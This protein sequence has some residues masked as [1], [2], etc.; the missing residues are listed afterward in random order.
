MPDQCVLQL[1]STLSQEELVFGF[2]SFSQAY[3]GVKS[4]PLF[5][6]PS[7]HKFMY[8]VSMELRHLLPPS[9]DIEFEWNALHPLI[10]GREDISFALAIVAIIDSSTQRMWLSGDGEWG[11]KLSK[12][13]PD[14]AYEMVKLSREVRGF[15]S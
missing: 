6:D 8:F 12:Q 13:F 5:T 15:I 14:L 10:C 11:Q 3:Y 4:F 1:T 2:M 7:W 9:F